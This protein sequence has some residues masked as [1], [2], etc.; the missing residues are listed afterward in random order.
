MNISDHE[1]LLMGMLLHNLNNTDLLTSVFSELSY[2][3]FGEKDVSDLY[4]QCA[5]DYI[6]GVPI[7]E[8]S[9]HSKTQVPMEVIDTLKRFPN[10]VGITGTK[11]YEVSMRI[12]HTAGRLR[13][14]QGV[15][16]QYDA[17]FKN[18]EE[19][20]SEVGDV[21][22]FINDFTAKLNTNMGGIKTGY[23]NIG[24]A[25]DKALARLDQ[26]EKGIIVD[27]LPTGIPSLHSFFIPRPKSFGVIQGI[28][29]M[30]KTQIALQIAFGVAY[31]LKSEGKPGVVSINSLETPEETLI[32]RIACML[33]SVDSVILESGQL[34]ASK[35]DQFKQCIEMLDDYPIEINDDRHITTDQVLWQSK[36]QHAQ[37]GRVLGLHDYIE[38]FADR[39][40]SEELRVSGATRSL[41]TIPGDLGSCEIILSQVNNS[42]MQ[43]STKIAGLSKARYSGAIEQAVE[44]GLEIY[45]PPQMKARNIPFTCPDGMDPELAHLLV[46]KNKEY[47]VGRIEFNWRANYKQFIDH[48]FGMYEGV[49]YEDMAD[50]LAPIDD[51]SDDLD[52]EDFDFDDEF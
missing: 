7:S 36:V 9:L 47:G 18:F 52:F 15:V 42:V 27:I 11:G 3:R 50:I 24:S 45:N 39:G 17:M 46:L 51:T 37:R 32:L 21:E 10:R 6:A 25:I 30:G 48:S 19:T 14:I 2:D 43:T 31:K 20:V 38:L 4:Q 35:F 34:S 29:S 44:W 49:V 5:H 40:D 1:R 41:R 16:S 28:S 26:L 8:L 33:M 12:I 13:Q 23:N 22:T